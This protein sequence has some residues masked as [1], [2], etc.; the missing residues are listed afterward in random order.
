MASAAGYDW[1]TFL[2]DYGHD[3]VFV[4]VCKGVVAQFAPH[5]RII[6]VCH[7]ITPQDVEMGATQLAGAMPYL[8][9]GIHLAVVDPRAS[10]R[11]ASSYA[12]VTA[13]CSSARTTGCSRSRGTCAV[14][15]SRWWRSPTVSCGC[16]TST[17]RSA[18]ATSMRRSRATSPPAGR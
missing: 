17:P 11:G 2:S 8:P 15:S 4:G 9:V 16:P 14:A 1:V 6:D 12:P 18:D 3:D 13:R 5:V 7:L 10:T